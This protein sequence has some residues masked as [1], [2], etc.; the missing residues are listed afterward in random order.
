MA[1]PSS[2]PESSL[3]VVQRSFVDFDKLVEELSHWDLDLVQLSRGAF[4]GELLQFGSFAKNVH[5]TEAR[6]GQTLLQ[7]GGPPLGLRTIVVP[8][9]ERV[10]FCWRGQTVTG[11]DLIIF[12]LGADLHATSRSDFHVYTCSFPEQLLASL[13]LSSGIEQL[14][15]LRGDAAV[16]RCHEPTMKALRLNLSR[17]SESASPLTESNANDLRTALTSDLPT[18]LLSV[19]ATAESSNAPKIQRKRLMALILAEAYIKRHAMTDIRITDIARHAQVSQR[20]LEYA[21]VERFGITPKSFLKAYR[22]NLARRALRST[23]RKTG[24]ITDIANGLG[25]WHMGQFAADYRAQFDELPS[26]TLNR[27]D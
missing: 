2:K 18:R 3:Y 14:D 8:A 24:T 25:F 11:N 9:T 4:Q 23:D 10:S 26:Q 12:P 17:L 7:Q 16:I 27:A 15:V 21:F 13:S 22:L 19:I 20:T 6:F 1:S 5:I